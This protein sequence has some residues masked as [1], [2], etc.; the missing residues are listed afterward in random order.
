MKNLEDELAGDFHADV[1]VGGSSVRITWPQKLSNIRDNRRQ[2]RHLGA[3]TLRGSSPTLRSHLARARG[4]GP[5][6]TREKA[7]EGEEGIPQD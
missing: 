4:A 2:A 5:V 1:S 3:Q 7:S 6:P